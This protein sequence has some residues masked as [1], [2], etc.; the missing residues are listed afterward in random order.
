[1]SRNFWTYL[2]LPGSSGLPE[3]L[4][5]HVIL[6]NCLQTRVGNNVSQI[7]ICDTLLCFCD[8]TWV[9]HSAEK[10]FCDALLPEKEIFATQ[11]KIFILYPACVKVVELNTYYKSILVLNVN[12]QFYSYVFQ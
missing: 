6:K 12:F 2:G 1:M 10:G 9:I 4:E 11:L 5:K 7:A 8:A 3:K